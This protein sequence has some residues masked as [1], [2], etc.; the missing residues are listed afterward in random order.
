MAGPNILIIMTLFVVNKWGKGVPV[1][2]TSKVDPS[3]PFF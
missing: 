3:D 2:E 1:V